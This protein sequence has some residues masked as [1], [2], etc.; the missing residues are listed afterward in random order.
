MMRNAGYTLI[1]ILVV[2]FIL[3]I[4]TS[5]ALLSINQNDNKQM[6]SFANEVTQLMTLAEEQAMLEPKVLGLSMG[7]HT[8][9]FAS[10][11]SGKNGKKNSWLPMQDVILGKHTIPRNMQ[12]GVA[13]GN[14]S[15]KTDQ[16]DSFAPQ[17]IISMN[18]GITPFAIYVGKKG[19]KP[20]YVITG[21]GD[22]NITNKLL[23]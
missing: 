21:D 16:H 22:G 18:G 3:G 11:Q 14:G 9:Q 12:M 8:F 23:S 20:R 4:V 15:L 7:E 5:V 13:L 19:Q 17:I 6:E 2:L 1:E 10:L